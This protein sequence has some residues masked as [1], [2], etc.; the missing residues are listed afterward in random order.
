MRS[1][2]F[3]YPF[4]ETGGIL[5]GA[6]NG[7]NIIVP[8][9][10][11]SGP[12][13]VRSPVRFKPDVEWQQERLDKY[14]ENYGLNYVGSFHR[15]PGGYTRPSLADHK[16]AMRILSDPDWAVDEIV[17]PIIIFEAATFVVYPYYICRNK[18]EFR[19]TAVGVVPDDHSLMNSIIKLREAFDFTTG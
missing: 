6:A 19:L 16:T 15:H 12:G 3:R 1:E 7:G 11:G 2:C 9:I 17:F 18:P 13:A 14:F 5:I 10:I 4:L 8:L